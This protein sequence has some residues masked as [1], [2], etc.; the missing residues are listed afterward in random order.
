MS[1]VEVKDIIKKSISEHE[2]ENKGQPLRELSICYD[3]YEAFN[4]G[5]LITRAGADLCFPLH[6]H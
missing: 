5:I 3:L 2:A 4:S 1:R 6:A